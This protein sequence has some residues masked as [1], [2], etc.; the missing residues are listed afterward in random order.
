MG[1]AQGEGKGSERVVHEFPPVFDK[2][3]S[4][5]LILGTMP[6]P[7]SRQDGFYYGHPRNRFWKVISS[8]LEAD[9]P[10]TA[11]E[12]RRLLLQNGIAL[13]DVVKSCEIAGASDLSIRSAE[14]N[15]IGNL[16]SG[17]GIRAIFFNGR[18]AMQLYN[19]LCKAVDPGGK[20]EKI[21]LPSTSPAN[22]AFSLERLKE[23]YR[24]ILRYLS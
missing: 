7:A 12:K 10:K 15:D 3:T 1:A 4:K 5:L 16:I 23:E 17:S 9:E 6:S 24:V 21:C 22:A 19:S 18:K 13:W 2:M 11:D 14:A 8:L 20:V